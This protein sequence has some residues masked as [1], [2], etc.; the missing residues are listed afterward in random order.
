MSLPCGLPELA[1]VELGVF[2]AALHQRV[3]V[4]DL[5]DVAVLHVEDDGGVADRGESVRDYEAGAALHQRRHGVL[6]D[7]FGVGVDVAGGFVED[8]DLRWR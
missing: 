8:H 6:D 5:L 1:V 3:V 4:A 7:L 2:A